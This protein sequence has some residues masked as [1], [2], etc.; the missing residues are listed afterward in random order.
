M[1]RDVKV[2]LGLVLVWSIAYL[3]VLIL[4]GGRVVRS[5]YPACQALHGVGPSEAQR[6]VWQED[7]DAHNRAT[8]QPDLVN[9]N[10]PT[11]YLVVWS[12]GIALAGAFVFRYRDALRP[13]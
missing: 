13:G 2:F 4:V 12:V 8:R 6:A 9:D 3:V 5:D 11:S 7:C 1:L 10:A